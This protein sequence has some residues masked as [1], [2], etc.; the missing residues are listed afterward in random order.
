MKEEKEFPLARLRSRPV[1]A[2]KTSLIAMLLTL[3]AGVSLSGQEKPA[4][5]QPAAGGPTAAENWWQKFWNQVESHRARVNVWPEPF[6]HQDR[7]LVRGPFRQM[8]DNGW[9]Y[10]NTLSDYL[11]DPGTNELT[12][13]GQAKLHY[14]LTQIPPHRRQVYVLEATTEDATAVRVAS[15]YRNLAQIAPDTSPCAVMTTKI[16]PRGGEGWY[17][18]DVEQAYRQNIPPPR[19]S[20]A[21]GGRAAGGAGS[22]SDNNGNSGNGPSNG[23]GGN[24]GN[25]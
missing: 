2:T 6:V 9:K 10:Q 12:V 13:A 24:P 4:P 3:V 25:R 8:V 16:V 11:F 14:I 22:E 20:S 18:Y 15:V 1:A 7:E 23:N 21:A 19:L 5:F 17:S